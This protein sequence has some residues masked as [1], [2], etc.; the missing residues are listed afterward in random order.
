[1]KRQ[2]AKGRLTL[3][4]EGPN[5]IGRRENLSATAVLQPDGTLVGALTSTTSG[6]L[7]WR[8]VRTA[9]R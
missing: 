8:A 3:S 9:G 6:N 2:F 4:G 5:G 7:K 1:M